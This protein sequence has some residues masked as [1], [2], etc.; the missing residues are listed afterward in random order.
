MNAR[1]VFALFAM[2]ALFAWTG[3]EPSTTPTPATA[4]AMPITP[5]TTAGP[6]T[7]RPGCDCLIRAT[8]LMDPAS[9]APGDAVEVT[10]VLTNRG[11]CAYAEAIVV[12]PVVTGTAYIP[13]TVTGGATY[14]PATR[15]VRW[16]DLFLTQ[17]HPISYQ[18]RVES[19]TPPGPLVIPVAVDPR[20]QH[21][22][23]FTVTVTAT[24]T[25]RP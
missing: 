13:D 18:V 1:I 17:A 22:D 5:T 20:C 9:A 12:A 2:L 8:A 21:Q 7:A 11:P 19:D 4:T 10:L 14:D 3:C 24:V 16:F 23:P 25:T 15:S 6:P